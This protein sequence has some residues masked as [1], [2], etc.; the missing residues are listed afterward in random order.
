MAEIER[1]NTAKCLAAAGS[2]AGAIETLVEYARDPRAI[3]GDCLTDGDTLTLVL[4]AARLIMEATD[5]NS[6]PLYTAIRREL[7]SMHHESQE[8]DWWWRDLDPDDAGDTPHEA[9]RNVPDYTVCALSS[10]YVG[11]S[12]F[13]VRVPTSSDDDETE[14][15]LFDTEAEALKAARSR[16]ARHEGKAHG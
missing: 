16:A 1:L 10:S 2:L 6:G 12:M 15:L 3:T 14:V 5:E 11:P 7:D 9:L 4:D 13:A 8:P